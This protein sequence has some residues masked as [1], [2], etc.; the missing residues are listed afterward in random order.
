M[1]YANVFKVKWK[2]QLP[3]TCKVF[4][5][6]PNHFLKMFIQIKSLMVSSGHRLLNFMKKSYLLKGVLEGAIMNFVVTVQF[7]LFFRGRLKC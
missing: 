6:A 1:R 7:P 3:Q 2:N 4:F 5:L